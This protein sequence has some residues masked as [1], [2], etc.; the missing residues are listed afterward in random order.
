MQFTL[1]KK[2]LFTI[3][4]FTFFIKFVDLMLNKFVGLGNPLIYQHSKIYGY[5][6]KPNQKIKRRAKTITINDEGMRNLK[7][8]KEKYEKKILFIGDSVT[9]GVSLVN[10]EDTF[11]I[12]SCE[13]IKTI[14]SIC[15]N[16]AVNGYGIEA[17]N[18]KLQFKKINDEDLLVLVFIGN[19]FERGLIHLGIQPYF[20]KKI[21]NFLP[22]LTEI[23]LIVIDKLRNKMRF[24]YSNISENKET[25]LNYQL[26]QIEKLKKTI[27]DNKKEYVIFYSP[28][29][30]ELNNNKKYEYI[31]IILSKEF[32]NFIDL[33]DDLKKYKNEI[34]FDNIHLNKFGHK[35]YSD[36]IYKK[37][38][39]YLNF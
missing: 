7:H 1:I 29:Y 31:K 12:K 23:S 10:D 15:G 30:S 27:I 2:I 37:I 8:W 5:D 35:I 21:T 16:Y 25:Y 33:T 6:I 14:K 24:K 11:V 18:N 19:N 13:K 17:I 9:F 22:A 20:S 36:L 26:I 34:Y 38:I 39:N 32:E 28:E 4:I 3:F